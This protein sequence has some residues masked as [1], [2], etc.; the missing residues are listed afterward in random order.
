M[1]QHLNI[2]RKWLGAFNA[3]NLETLLSLYDEEATHFSPKLKVKQPETQ[4]MIKGKE[5]LRMWWKEA[6]EKIP[7]LKY[8][9]VTLT[10]NEERVF[11]EYTRLAD[12]DAPLSV[13]EVLEI[14]KDKIVFSRVY[15]A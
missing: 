4:G 11:M 5:S 15:H 1:E 13:A 6:F 12:G 9:V 3:K 2:A 14:E 10:A 7:S 8:E